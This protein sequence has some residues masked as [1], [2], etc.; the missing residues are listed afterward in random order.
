MKQTNWYRVGCLLTASLLLAACGSSS[1]SGSSSGSMNGGSGSGAA[2]NQQSAWRTGLSMVTRADSEDRAGEIHTILA[3]VLLDEDGRIVQ[4]S[5]DELESSITA[6]P[7]GVVT[8]PTDYRT[9]RQKGEKDYPLGAVSSIEKGWAEQADFFGEYLAGMTGEQV[10][11]LEID[12]DGYASDP[13]LLSGCTITV[14]GYRDAVARACELAQPV[15]SASGD[16]LTLGVEVS[17]PAGTELKAT[18]DKDAAA[19]VD[20]NAVAITMDKA[21]RVT[22]AIWDEAEPRLTVGTDG[23]VDA[24]DEVL[25]KLE[26]GDD[27]GMRDASALGKEWYEHSEGFCDYLKG[28]TAEQIEEIPTD[29]SAADLK[30]LC[31]IGIED[32]QKAL[33]KALESQATA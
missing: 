8:M 25:S 3:A 6:D 22:G 20:I 13:D 31:T 27:Y 26:M 12:K 30:S 10:E 11:K 14:E 23:M 17:S 21:G 19:E 2:Q 4:V 15:G 5:L 18:E 29:G 24:P 9:K 16:T 33:L 28:K 1:S 32:V 7:N